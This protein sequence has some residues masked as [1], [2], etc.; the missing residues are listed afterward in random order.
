VV[1]ISAHFTDAEY[2]VR[3]LD[4]WADAYLIEP[5]DPAELVAVMRAVVRGRRTEDLRL[6]VAPAAAASLTAF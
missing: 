1:V 5:A 6:P 2:R 4:A 3:G